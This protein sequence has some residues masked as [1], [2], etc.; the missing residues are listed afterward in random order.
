MQWQQIAAISWS[1]RNG[2]EVDKLGTEQRIT[3]LF[4]INRRRCLLLLS[5]IV[6]VVV[7]TMDEDEVLSYPCSSF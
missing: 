3:R 4:F 6:I 7:I 1:G 2:Y 5:T